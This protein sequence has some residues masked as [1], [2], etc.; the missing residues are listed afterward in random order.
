LHPEIVDGPEGFDVNFF[1]L[2]LPTSSEGVIEARDDQ[3]VVLD[4]ER[5]R[6][7][8]ELGE[9]DPLTEEVLDDQKLAV[10]YPNGWTRASE[11]LMTAGDGPRELVSLGT[12]RLDRGQ[13]D[14]VG[15]PERAIES[16]GPANAFV[17]LQESPPGSAFP[18]RPENFHA[19]DGE[20]PEATRCLDNLDDLLI[21]VFRFQDGGRSFIAYVALGDAASA[22]TRRDVW[23]IL[24]SMIVCDPNSPPG[25]C[26]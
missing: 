8:S 23:Q 3:G 18:G 13:R 10:Y 6:S 16:L 11:S 22:R 25:D 7:L 17:T 2:F 19:A 5:L 24:D 1:A 14:C 12:G 26:L 21:R 20:I 15:I 4:R 9:L